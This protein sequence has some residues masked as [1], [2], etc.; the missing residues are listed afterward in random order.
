[1][2]EEQKR[3]TE[4]Q[5]DGENYAIGGGDLVEEEL[6]NLESNLDT[7]DTSLKA[8]AETLGELTDLPKYVRS[9]PD[10]EKG[11]SAQFGLVEDTYYDYIQIEEKED[12]DEYN[13][14]LSLFLNDNNFLKINN[15][16]SGSRDNISY[17]LNV[18]DFT[19]SSNQ[20]H[21]QIGE[22]AAILYDYNSIAIGENT[23]SAG[24]ETI[25][26]GESTVAQGTSTVAIGTDVSVNG[27]NSFSLGNHIELVGNNSFALGE[28]ILISGSNKFSI[29]TYNETNSDDCFLIGN[30]T[31]NSN[32]SNLFSIQNDGA[33]IIK[34]T[35]SNAFTYG[36]YRIVDSAIKLTTS[37]EDSAMLSYI[38]GND[39]IRNTI[40]FFNSLP[41][42]NSNNTQG[43]ELSTNRFTSEDTYQNSLKLGIKKDG[44]KTVTL[45]DPIVWREALF[46]DSIKL[47]RRSSPYSKEVSPSTRPW[48]VRFENLPKGTYLVTGTLYVKAL[49]S[50]GNSKAVSN[51]QVAAKL[52][53]TYSSPNTITDTFAGQT[54]LNLA[55]VSD[56]GASETLNS[57]NVCGINHVYEGAS[58]SL[59]LTH[60]VSSTTATIKAWGDLQIINLR[61]GFVSATDIRD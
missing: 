1:M 15:Q 21:I 60:N 24:A 42:T 51:A 54:L 4:I 56:G 26:I 59:C 53:H 52:I 27:S 39:D 35:N 9:T 14:K 46:A 13:H 16:T 32:R 48:I 25:A 12:N 40:N 11:T 33:V 50:N 28:G 19:V 29:G 45:S 5:I 10:T 44:T 30:G 6:E 47:A 2:A 34:K 43:L 41:V 18:N 38:D 31:N 8:V 3:I 57:I 17:E 36:G 23:V 49:D 20:A 37:S 58:I 55:I 7:L 22:G 61:S